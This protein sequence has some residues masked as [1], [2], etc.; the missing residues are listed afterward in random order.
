MRITLIPS[1]DH[2]A[3]S[4]APGALLSALLVQ[5]ARTKMNLRNAKRQCRR[6][7]SLVTADFEVN[8]SASQFELEAVSLDFGVRKVRRGDV[9]APSGG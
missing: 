1:S 9:N 5:A 7:L 2:D 4:S 8:A 3:F 6:E